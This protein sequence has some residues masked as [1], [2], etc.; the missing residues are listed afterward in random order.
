M[1]KGQDQVNFV[2]VY[3][4]FKHIL[5]YYLSTQLNYNFILPDTNNLISSK[6][7]TGFC[8]TLTSVDFSFKELN[9]L[10]VIAYC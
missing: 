6:F 1:H 4:L 8:L 7:I 10:F 2:K 5:L 9:I 3:I